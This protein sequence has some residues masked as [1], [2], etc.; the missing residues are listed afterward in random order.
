MKNLKAPD[1]DGEETEEMT[2]NLAAAKEMSVNAWV[3]AVLSELEEWKNK[4]QH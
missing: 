4:G 1:E 2:V 3:A